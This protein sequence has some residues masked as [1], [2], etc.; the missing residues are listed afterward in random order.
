MNLL[1]LWSTVLLETQIFPQL[2]KKFPSVRGTP[3]LISLFTRAC[4]VFFNQSHVN[5]IHTLSPT[6]LKSILSSH[7]CP[8]YGIPSWW[9]VMHS[10]IIVPFMSWFTKS[11]LLSLSSTWEQHDYFF[12]SLL[13]SSRACVILLDSIM[14]KVYDND[15]ISLRFVISS[16]YFTYRSSFNWSLWSPFLISPTCFFYA[17]EPLP[18][19]LLFKLDDEHLN[20]LNAELNPICHF[21]V[22][23]GDLTFMGPSIVSVFQYTRI[24]N[25]MQR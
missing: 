7:L 10:N 3:R 22:L 25:K 11:I 13:T 15:F 12:S 9:F 4:Q 21:L 1:T 16:F 19:W 5:T 18:H 23:L 6:H 24:S 14:V 2:L 8:V 20:P 17:K